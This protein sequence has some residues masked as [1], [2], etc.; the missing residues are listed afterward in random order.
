MSSNAEP[1]RELTPEDVIRLCEEAKQRG[2]PTA[3]IMRRYVLQAV[4]AVV[5]RLD[6]EGR[7]D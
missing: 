5:A 6:A 7:V 1:S 3:P 2:E 4:D